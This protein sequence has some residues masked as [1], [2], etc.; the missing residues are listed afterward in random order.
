MTIEFLILKIETMDLSQKAVKKIRNLI[1]KL[2]TKAIMT[3]GQHFRN[4]QIK[5]EILKIINYREE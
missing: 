4:E 3:R 5:E 1:L 2:S